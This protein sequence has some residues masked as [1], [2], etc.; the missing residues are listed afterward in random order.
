MVI[1][2][3]LCELGTSQFLSTEAPN[4]VNPVVLDCRIAR[5][6][7]SARD[8]KLPEPLTGGFLVRPNLLNKQVLFFVGSGNAV[9]RNFLLRS[10]ATNG[11]SS[12]VTT[13]LCDFVGD[14][15]RRGHKFTSSAPH[16]YGFAALRTEKREFCSA[17]I[18]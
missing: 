7:R 14:W 10:C 13:P 5:N 6:T 8:V 3:L 17:E 4:F 1:I 2:E 18:Q 11:G 16:C 9:P 12:V 15:F